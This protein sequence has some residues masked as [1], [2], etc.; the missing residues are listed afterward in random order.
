MGGALRC[1]ATLVSLRV[2]ERRKRAAY[3]ELISGGPQRL[4]VLRSSEIRWALE[5]SSAAARQR[6]SARSSPTGPARTAN[7]SHLPGRDDGG[8]LS[9]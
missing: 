5:R 3:P 1:D 7:S 6:L 2:A 9:P 4:L 8:R